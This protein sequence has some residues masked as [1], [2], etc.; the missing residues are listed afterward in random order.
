MRR[1][2]LSL[3]F[4]F[5]LGLPVQAREAVKLGFFPTDAFYTE[6]GLRLLISGEGLEF[7]D[8]TIHIYRDR[9]EF[10]FIANEA[11]RGVRGRYRIGDRGRICHQLKDGTRNCGTFVRSDY[12]VVYVRSDG[13]R[14]NVKAFLNDE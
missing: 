8:G 12:K 7:V 1:M 5:G 14:I 11:S 4:A 3:L 9:G 2:V 6:R 13:R 10:I